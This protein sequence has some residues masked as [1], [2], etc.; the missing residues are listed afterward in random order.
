MLNLRQKV[1]SNPVF[2]FLVVGWPFELQ[3]VALKIQQVKH[4]SCSFLFQQDRNWFRNI[5]LGLLLPCDQDLCQNPVWLSPEYTYTPLYSIYSR[6]CQVKQNGT[7]CCP[8][9]VGGRLKYEYI[10]L[11][12]NNNKGIE[13]CKACPQIPSA[14]G[15]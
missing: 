10:F 2:R 14:S 13:N 9:N 4:C 3:I 8:K 1:V 6:P 11:C 7:T 12:L 15:D 5:K